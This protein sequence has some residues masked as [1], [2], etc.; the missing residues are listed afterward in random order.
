MYE[1]EK[2]KY[3]LLNRLLILFQLRPT[4][5]AH[6]FSRLCGP[7]TGLRSS[8]SGLTFRSDQAPPPGRLL[9]LRPQLSDPLVLQPRGQL[10]SASH[11]ALRGQSFPG[12]NPALTAQNGPRFRNFTTP[13]DTASCLTEL[14]QTPEWC[15]SKEK[16]ASATFEKAQS[17]R[18]KQGPPPNLRCGCS[19]PR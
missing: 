10:S 17:F 19:S 5:A 8:V 13:E 2:P 7:H 14:C 18:S 3:K 15:F 1:Y 11:R 16:R 4:P 12:L 6:L 9:P